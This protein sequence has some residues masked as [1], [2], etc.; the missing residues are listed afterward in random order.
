MKSVTI[1]ELRE[2][3]DEV[4]AEVEKGETLSITRDGKTLFLM[5]P[6]LTITPPRL[7]GRAQ[8]VK[9]GPRLKNLQTDA[10]Q[11]IIDERDR[12]RSEKKWRP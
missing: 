2:R 8:D 9:L 4:I 1:E 5:K 12:Q 7:P 3:L 10:A 11:L 6:G